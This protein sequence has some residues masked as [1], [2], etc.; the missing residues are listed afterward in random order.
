MPEVFSPGRFAAGPG[1]HWKL[2]K[3]RKSTKAPTIRLMAFS[4]EGETR[5]PLRVVRVGRV[6]A[7]MEIIMRKWEK[8]NA[9][10]LTPGGGPR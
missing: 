4:A 5:V 8:T 7:A 3:E 10:S 2:V 1:W 9:S 6:A